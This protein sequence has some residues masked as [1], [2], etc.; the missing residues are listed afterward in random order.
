MIRNETGQSDTGFAVAIGLCVILVAGL[1]ASLMFAFPAYN[2]YQKRAHARN[3]VQVNHIIIQQQAQRVL[4]TEQEAKIRYQAS[5]GVR[6]AQDEIAKTLT[7]LYVQFELTQALEH[8][9]TSGQ[10]NVII[11]LPTDP[12][13]G[14]P[15]VPTSNATPGTAAGK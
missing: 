10:N 8:V 14:L 13:S 5:V 4:I 6:K 7:P 11:Y 15:V 1:I 2:R 12:K 9:A 3:Q